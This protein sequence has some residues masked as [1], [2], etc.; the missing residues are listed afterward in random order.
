[1]KDSVFNKFRTRLVK[2]GILKAFLCGLIAG[3]AALLISATVCW[4]VGFKAVW[5][6]AIVFAAVT[7]IAVP[8]LY[9]V[10]FRPTDANV[11]RRM[12]GLGLEERVI[13]MR[14][15]EGQTSFMAMRQRQDAV[16]AIG[17]VDA[18]LIKITVSI[19]VIIAL[20]VVAVLSAGMT[21]VSA[22]A[23]NDIVKSGIDVIGGKD[24]GK[25]AT[26][27][28]TYDVDGEG[29]IEGDIV[30]LVEETGN[31]EKVLAVP[32]DGY[33]FAGWVGADYGDDGN[34][35]EIDDLAGF[36]N[37]ERQEVNVKSDM[38]LVAVFVEVDE[39]DG[40]GDGDEGDE[41]EGDDAPGQPS[42]SGEPSEP[43]QDNGP[44]AGG[45]Y[46]DRLNFI[47]DGNTYY[48]GDTL[49]DAEGEALGSIGDSDGDKGAIGDYF[50]SIK[51]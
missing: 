18:K 38:K 28:V 46:D 17:K 7:A 44:G 40:D 11:A 14:E 31:T 48:G 50:G 20:A 43:N 23:A 13:T 29:V 51:D 2:E 26:Y 8:V 36:D 49:T 16:N 42:E 5:I 6:C 30:Q 39:G 1:M 41:G 34:W 15:L 19:P 4:I 9:F 27:T 12:D 33:A 35:Y 47:I 24:D 45:F 10:F 21:T 25:V 37:P 32:M 22:L 3:F